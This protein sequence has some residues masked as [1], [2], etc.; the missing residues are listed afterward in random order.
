MCIT[1]Y[2]N[3]SPSSYAVAHEKIDM[4]AITNE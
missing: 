3:I 4:E 2:Y 1:V